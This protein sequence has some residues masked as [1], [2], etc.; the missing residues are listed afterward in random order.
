MSGRLLCDREIGTICS[1]RAKG[2]MARVADAPQGFTVT[3]II[4]D[5]GAIT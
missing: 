2:T 5:D 1:K 3:V 4:A